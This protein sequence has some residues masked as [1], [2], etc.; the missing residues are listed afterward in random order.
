MQTYEITD[1][2]VLEKL[3]YACYQ[4]RAIEDIINSAN[5]DQNPPCEKWN[6]YLQELRNELK[7]NYDAIVLKIAYQ[8]SPYTNFSYDI[9]IYKG[10]ITYNES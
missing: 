6:N 7:N 8:Y 4:L 1:E 5:E 9:D 2:K 3:R 10:S